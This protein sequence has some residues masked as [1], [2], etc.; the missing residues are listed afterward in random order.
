MQAKMNHDIILAPRLTFVGPTLEP[1]RYQETS[2]H[3]N[4][5]EHGRDAKDLRKSPLDR[6]QQCPMEAFQILER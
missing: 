3:P 4:P 5:R 2:H 1:P 6:R